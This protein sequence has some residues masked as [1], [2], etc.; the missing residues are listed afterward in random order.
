MLWASLSE[1]TDPCRRGPRASLNLRTSRT[2]S[3]TCIPSLSQTA[4]ILLPPP[5]PK[6]PRDDGELQ[7]P[8]QLTTKHSPHNAGSSHLA[9]R[10]PVPLK[11]K[12]SFSASLSASSSTTHLSSKP[13]FPAS[14]VARTRISLICVRANFAGGSRRFA[15]ANARC[16]V[17]IVLVAFHAKNS[18]PP[19]K[20]TRSKLAPLVLNVCHSPSVSQINICSSFTAVLQ[21]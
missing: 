8:F 2:H 19:A 12:P 18:S 7:P 4:S 20:T 16:V 3:S 10:Y 17:V 14:S 5:T 6:K 1:H 15:I 21:T 13:S 11:A 9:S